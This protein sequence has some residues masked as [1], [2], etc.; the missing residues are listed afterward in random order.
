MSNPTARPRIRSVVPAIE[1]ELGSEVVA[2]RY[3]F[4]AFQ[5]AGANPFD[6]SLTRLLEGATPE[7]AYGFL[8]CGMSPEDRGK[9]TDEL[10]AREC[11]PMLLAE[12]VN[13]LSQQ[14]KQ[15][16]EANGLQVDDNAER[17]PAA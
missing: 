7:T 16:A 11:S 6:G 4:S 12:V 13:A 10:L 14:I 5:E 3:T 1:I 8:R 2:L 17:P 9:W 15:S